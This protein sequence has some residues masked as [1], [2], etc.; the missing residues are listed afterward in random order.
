MNKPTTV[1]TNPVHPREIVVACLHYHG[2][3]CELASVA[4]TA[5]QAAARE[6]CD[7]FG[8]GEAFAEAC[9]VDPDCFW[10]WSHVRDSSEG[11]IRRASGYLVDVLA[12]S[13]EICDALD[14]IRA[15]RKVSA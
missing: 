15:A 5:V 9:A 6:L 4:G 7:G 1:E 12:R 10:D 13:G 2:A 3:C 11:A 14:R 8:D